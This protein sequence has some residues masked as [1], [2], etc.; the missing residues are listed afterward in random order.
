MDHFE[1]A[2][3]LH[4]PEMSEMAVQIANEDD[5]IE[6]GQIEWQRFPDCFPNLFIRDI[7]RLIKKDVALL[8][9]MSDVGGIFERLSMMYKLAK[10]KPHALKFI[11]PYFP[12]G[13]ME[14]SDHQ[15][16]VATAWT[17]SKLISGVPPAGHGPIDFCTFDL[18]ALQNEYYFGDNITLRPK[19]GIRLLQDR[20]HDMDV[21]IGFPDAGS[22][23]R[24]K[25]M[26]TERDAS[27]WYDFVVCDK[28][29]KGNERI[30][31]VKEG[32][33]SGK[34]VLIVDDLIHSG[35]T[36]I[37]C[38]DALLGAGASAVSVFATHGVME[39]DAYLRFVDAGFTHVFITDSV[40]STAKRVRGLGQFEVISIK[41]A[42]ID[43][44]HGEY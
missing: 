25:T 18:H 14:R 44:I 43:A 33:P 24:Y 15:G 31:T 7:D 1:R 38:K 41:P 29:R 35:G 22:W 34:H 6:L 40:P 13:T 42:L 20:I 30:V 19:S 27:R 11:V 3:L 37:K 23:K 36:L 39:N 2:V 4:C 26:F 32:N 21:V 5:R 9:S 28:V 16:Q 12:T 17:L 10:F 8:M